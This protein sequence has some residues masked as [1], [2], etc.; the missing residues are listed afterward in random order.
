M[1]RL[2]QR[3]GY[4]ER[5]W[6]TR[7]A[8]VE[9]RILKLRR[10]SCFP[11]FLAPRRMAEKALTAVIIA[12][13]INS[14]GRGEIIG[15]EIGTSEAE[16][17]WSAF[18]S[19]LTQRGLW[20]AKLVVSAAHEGV[21]ACRHKGAVNQSVALP[22]ALHARRPCPCQ[23]IGAPR[24]RSDPAQGTR[25]RPIMDGAK[26]DVLAA[27][28]FPK[29][30]RAKLHGTNPI[31]RLNGE[32]R[33][34][35]DAVC[36]FPNDDANIRLVGAILLEQNDEWAVQSARFISLDTIIQMSDDPVISLPA[37]AN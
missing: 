18:L 3:N 8:T 9:P 32:I 2:A 5:D 13:S 30:H 21:Q 37:V 12:T 29:E 15:M 1:L 20:G 35:T 26:P 7:A 16:P 17:N 23:E 25:T 33:Q 14:D 31:E 10:C 36:I 34:R 4:R 27:M 24:G 19:K 6:E 11:G 22:H 28:T